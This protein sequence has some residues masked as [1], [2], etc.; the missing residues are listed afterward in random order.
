MKPEIYEIDYSSGEIKKFKLTIVEEEK[1]KVKLNEIITTQKINVA[2]NTNTNKGINNKMELYN[3]KNEKMDIN[4]FVLQE[5]IYEN[6]L[7]KIYKVKYK[8]DE[9]ILIM[10]IFNKNKLIKEKL[11]THLLS[12]LNM[13]NQLVSPFFVS[14]HHFFQNKENIYITLDYCPYNLS[15]YKNEMIYSEDKIK[16]YIAEIIVAFEYLHKLDFTYKYLSLENIFITADNHIKLADLQLNKISNNFKN[17]YDNGTRQGAG[18]SADIYAIGALLYELVSGIP[19]LYMKNTLS[20]NDKNNEE[21]LF[22]PNFFSDNLKD[23]I[24]KLLCKDH[25]KRIG[26]KSKKQ[27]KAHPWFHNINWDDVLTKNIKPPIDFSL[28]KNKTDNSNI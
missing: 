6:N 14:L 26:L 27:I 4:S 21:E 2:N 25:N 22:L 1:Q 9:S 13:Q 18:I 12:Q 15:F 28:I 10:K 5:L 8:S 24:S 23:L 20:L 11:L 7:F 3:S 19:P 16:L 17:Y